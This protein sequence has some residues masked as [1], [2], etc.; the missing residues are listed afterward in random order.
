MRA[1]DLNG[2]RDL[3][4]GFFEASGWIL[5]AEDVRRLGPG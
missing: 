2:A 3:G 4:D 5:T 1:I